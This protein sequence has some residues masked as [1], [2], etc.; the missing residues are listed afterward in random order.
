[1]NT[2]LPLPSSLE[3]S[4]GSDSVSSST[5]EDDDQNWDDWESDSFQKQE[6]P[7]LFDKS[8]LPSASEAIIYDRE[9]YGFD[10]NTVC[11]K[12]SKS[13]YIY[14]ELLVSN[15]WLRTQLSPAC[16]ASEL[17]SKECMSEYPY[18]CS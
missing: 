4:A 3:R 1:M 17:H 14:F 10:L 13:R 6:C 16:Q 11:S 7:S 18:K 12:L 5:G 15:C 8:S 9:K 2:K